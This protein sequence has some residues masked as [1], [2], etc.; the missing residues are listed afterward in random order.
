MSTPTGN[1]ASRLKEFISNKGYKYT[2][3]ERVVGFSHGFIG[4]ILSEKTTFSVKNA[5]K[6]FYVFPELNPTWLMTGRGPMEVNYLEGED[7]NNVNHSVNY[8]VNYSPKSQ[9]KSTQKKQPEAGEEVPG[10]AKRNVHK[11]QTSLVHPQA[12]IIEVPVN[13]TGNPTI[14]QLDIQAAAGLPY[15]VDDPE[16]LKDKPAFSLPG[17]QYQR[18]EYFSIQ[19]N[20][21]SM[22]DT[23]YHGD[24]LIC[25]RVYDLTEVKDNYVHVIVTKEGVVTKRVLNR[26]EKRG[27]LALK[28]DNEAYTTYDEPVGNILMVLR[29][30]GRITA[31]LKNRNAGMA[32]EVSDLKDR[33]EQLEKRLRGNE[34]F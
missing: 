32:R 29:A 23:I 15:H 12:E 30:T 22:E 4:K 8:S 16:Y 9:T 18:G 19:V 28:S 20:G 27:S 3:F 33:V 11:K 34:G 5:E 17:E 26:I 10:Y 31:I 25:E 1:I 14:V 24:W 2:E 13:E 7:E 6:I 21:D